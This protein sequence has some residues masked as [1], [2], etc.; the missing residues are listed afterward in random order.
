MK[1]LLVDPGASYSTADV[2]A[3]LLVGLEAHG[4][5]IVRYR[6]DQRIE[7]SRRWLFGAWRAARKQQPGI[8]R[9]T[10]ADVFYQAGTGLLERALRHEVDV[11]LVVSSMFLHPDVVI[12]LRRAGVRVAVLF[13]E[14]P[15]DMGDELRM[16]ALVDACWTCERSAVA[17]FAAVNPRAAYL[18][19]AWHPARHQ[20]GA[21]PGDAAFPAHDVVFV[22]SGFH[23][24]VTW[25]AGIDWTGIDLGLYGAWEMIGSRHRLRQFVRGGLVD[26]VDVAA[27]YRRARI[28]LN[29][30]RTSQGCGRQAPAIA[31]AESMNPRAYELAR[32]GAFHLSTG[33]AEVTEVFGA[34]VPI[35]TTPSETSAVIRSWL[36]DEAGRA[37]VEA[38]LPA[39][40][41]ES[42]WVARA[43]CVIGDLERWQVAR[44]A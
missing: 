18:P 38:R 20:P 36:A 7:R 43:A 15:Y 21:Q 33:R 25:L 19:H 14:S 9:P 13:T 32:C 22:G 2:S 5:S 42:S 24:R 37:A 6:L 16:A 28:G 44:A 26:N 17:A 35:V 27:L 3:G 31:H 8:T 23:E 10:V 11:V 29:L 12:L 41:A 4:V 30:Y 34:D 39:A 1:V 40:V